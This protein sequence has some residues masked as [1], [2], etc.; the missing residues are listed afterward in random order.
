M[1]TSGR[2]RRLCSGRRPVD[3]VD[4][5][6]PASSW[7]LLA[8]AATGTLR[9][10]TDCRAAAPRCAAVSTNP[11]VYAELP[12]AQHAFDVFRSVRAMESV[13]AVTRFLE[14]AHATEDRPRRQ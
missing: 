11:V 7:I 9:T 14:W 13:H 5:V 2:Q 8:L 3:T 4:V 1:A 10:G 6:V 12:G